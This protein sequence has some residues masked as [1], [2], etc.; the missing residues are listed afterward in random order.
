MLVLSGYT[1]SQAIAVEYVGQPTTR[2][3]PTEMAVVVERDPEH[4]HIVKSSSQVHSRSL[5]GFCGASS[6]AY[7]GVYLHTVPP[8]LFKSK[9]API[10]AKTIPRL[11]LCGAQLL[12]KLL[13]QVSAD[14]AAPV[15]NIHR[16]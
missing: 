2:G 5:H 13:P 11:E 7:G 9:V 16:D 3:S 15:E 8:S 10:K 4:R 14:L 12:F 1:S 6:R